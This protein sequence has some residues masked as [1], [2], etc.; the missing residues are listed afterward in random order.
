[1]LHGPKRATA[2]AVAEYLDAGEPLPRIGGFGVVGDAAGR[3][4]CILR[5]VELRIGHPAQ[6]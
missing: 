3:A 2:G 6:R 5:S 4:R 1:M